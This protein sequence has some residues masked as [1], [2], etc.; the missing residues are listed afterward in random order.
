MGLGVNGIGVDGARELARTL[1]D[2]SAC[3][4][5]TLGLYRNSLGDAGALVLSSVLA[6]NKLP[7]HSLYLGG[8]NVGN[9]GAEALARALSSNRYLQVLSLEGGSLGD[10]GAI[11]LA[12]A[13]ARSV[14]IVALDVRSCLPTHRNCKA[15]QMTQDEA[16]GVG[17]GKM[18]EKG[19]AALIEAV[20]KR[21]S[22]G[23]PLLKVTGDIDFT[24]PLKR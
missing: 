21:R 19:F 13:I 3:N 2:C 23:G 20:G 1:E 5:K 24:K 12:S 10:S 4:I 8:N 7:L 22:D 17:S 16:S 9:A 15:G 6:K 11:A 18:S 14:T